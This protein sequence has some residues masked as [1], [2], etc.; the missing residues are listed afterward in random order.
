M[1]QDKRPTAVAISE[2]GNGGIAPMPIGSDTVGN[3]VG[4]VR[5]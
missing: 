3:S 5:L 4:V 1:I 2:S